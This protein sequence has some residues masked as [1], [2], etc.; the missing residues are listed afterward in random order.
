MLDR[1]RSGVEG[2]I[3]KLGGSVPQ[4]RPALQRSRASQPVSDET[5]ANYT[6]ARAFLYGEWFGACVMVAS[7][8]LMLLLT[9]GHHV[10]PT[11]TLPVCLGTLAL[12]AFILVRNRIYYGRLGFPWAPKWHGVA[13]W[14]G[15]SAVLFWLLVALLV[16]LTAFGYGIGLGK[17]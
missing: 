11:I 14:L 3:T 5:L 9:W 2:S 10:R 16:V 4:P 17:A 8:T 12:G 1:F 15:L 7:Y 6:A 13:G